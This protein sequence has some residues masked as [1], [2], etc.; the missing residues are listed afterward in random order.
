M[1]EQH[2]PPRPPEAQTPLP[3]IRFA[4]VGEVNRLL[5]QTFEQDQQQAKLSPAFQ[6]YYRV[7]HLMPI[8]V[9]RLL[10]RHRNQSM[11]VDVDWYLAPEFADRLRRA[12]AVEADQT[13]LA[14]WPDE[15]RLAAVLTHDVETAEG[16]SR[17]S[18][19]AALEER[20]GFRSA[21]HFVPHKYPLDFGLLADLKRRGHEVGVHGYN[22][23]GRLFASRRVFNR[24]V[25]PI[26]RALQRFSCAGFR[27][28]MVHRNLQWLQALDI[29]YD[30]SCFDI[31]PF[32][33]MPGGVGGMW[34]FMA[35]RFVE[36]PYTMPQD[37]TLF[38]SLKMETTEV[39]RR[40]LVHLRAASAMALMLTHPDYLD[41]EPRRQLYQEFLEHLA[42][43]TD[44]WQ[45]LPSE[46]A[47]WWRQRDRL[48]YDSTAGT[49]E[50]ERRD[51]RRRVTSAPL[52]AVINI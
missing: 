31:D 33:P 42:E 8:G 12:V 49:D 40:K 48:Q 43:Q 25:R 21:W 39:W 24:R 47:R 23:D 44:C 13:V 2:A 16:V 18:E 41:T 4:F 5:E 7:R 36:L 45:A 50:T 38:V 28:P 29:D 46:V 34:P 3:E 19:L 27:A 14:P 22:H 10:Q 26:N 15:H 6:W 35:G 52:H 30:A 9:R 37:H 17:V 11:D 20:L 51:T 1:I 32:Q